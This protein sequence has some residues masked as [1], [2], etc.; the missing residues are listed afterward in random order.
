MSSGPER[1]DPDS[2]VVTPR[3]AQSFAGP[4]A[5]ERPG[6]FLESEYGPALCRRVLAEPLAA[7]PPTFR[8]IF[9]PS[10]GIPALSKTASG[11][12]ASCVTTFMQKCMP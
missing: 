2:A 6:I 1:D 11:T 5:R 3:Y 7:T 4:E 10:S 8:E 9:S 12:P